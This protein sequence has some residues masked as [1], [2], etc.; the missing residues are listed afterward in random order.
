[1]A[2]DDI[3]LLREF[4]A[5]QSEPAF[6]ALV[7]RHVALVHSSALRQTGDEHLAD[8]VTQA[9]FIILAQ[10]AV[11][12][13]ANTILPAWLYRTT[14]YAAG[15]ALKI[16]HRRRV[17]EHQA[18][19]GTMNDNEAL[20]RH[21]ET[22]AEAVWQQLAPLLDDAMNKLSERDRAP[23]VLRF[24]E[25]RPWREVA[26]MMQVSEDAA[27]KR[28]TRALEKLRKL[29]AKR[30]VMLTA[31]LIAGAIS[32]NSVK[33]APYILVKTISAAVMAKGAAA[34]VSTL[35][36]VKGTLKALAWSKYQSFIGVGAGV[37]AVVTGGILA[38]ATLRGQ[39]AKVP[40]S[41]PEPV[42]REV[43][44]DAAYI[45]LDSPPGGLSV[46]PDGKIVVA[47]SLFGRFL[48]P[49]A[50]T[51]GYFERGAIRLN[52]DGSLDRSFACYAAFPGSDSHRAHVDAL[53]DGGLF[54]SGLFDSIDGKAR[55][56]YA[57]LLGDGEVDESFVPTVAPAISNALVLGRTYLPGGT[58][59]AA[60]LSDGSV[61][62]LTANPLTV[63]RLDATG[64]LIL[65]ATNTSPLFP[66]HF[67]L[68]WTLQNAGFWG[69]W[70]GHEPIAWDRT[71]PATRRPM[72]RPLGQ[73]PFEDCAEQPSAA[74]AAE[75]F[76]ALFAEVP[77]ELCRVA[78]RLPDGGMVLGVQEKFINGSVVAPGNLMRFDKN[79]RRDF[80]FTNQ[81]EFDR[82]GA[83]TIRRQADGKFLVA[84]GFVKMNGKDF[85]GLV[86]LDQNG[87]TDPDFHCEVTG[88][89]YGTLVMDVAVQADGKIVICG[90]F[91]AVNGSKRQHIARLNPDGSLDDSFKN[92]FISLE[93]LQT[94]RRWPVYSLEK[95]KTTTVTNTTAPATA[96]AAP[97]PVALPETILI[98]SIESQNGVILIRFNGSTKKEYILQAKNS[99]GAGDWI[100]IS[101]NRS[102]SNGTGTF[103]DSEAAKYQMRFYRI[104]TP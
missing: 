45:S 80:N 31:A 91:T 103:S 76:K 53:S 89:N 25:N 7:E 9:V 21:S 101:T 93:E 4:S 34:G 19:L 8:E 60:A 48:D 38:T 50:G 56:G 26:G 98:T 100:N 87:Q 96:T 24:F 6:A 23:L 44:G 81:Y 54:A 85:P 16:Q 29:F 75:V 42:V 20:A 78:V 92:T 58:Y 104:A 3:S 52:T 86:R 90:A 12:L 28:V 66:P 1:M 33:A 73:L 84:G 37:A 10:K 57:R 55:P 15:N 2:P 36:V 83:M 5:S 77:L 71:T 61:A 94:H 74:D 22:E 13:G 62:V 88:P 67:G 47:A 39:P 18:Y 79:W 51:L 102:S 95:N 27:Q 41:K 63:Y 82:R 14:R 97:A 32:A 69:N 72:V 17:R 65:S 70:W 64:K 46:Q 49:Q 35:A 68:V 30:G 43:M 40:P 59:P 99:L 11:T